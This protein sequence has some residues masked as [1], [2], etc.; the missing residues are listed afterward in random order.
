MTE[1]ELH[2]QIGDLFTKINLMKVAL[3]CCKNQYAL[4]FVERSDCLWNRWAE[5]PGQGKANVKR[6]ERID[7]GT[8]T[9]FVEVNWSARIRELEWE[10]KDEGKTAIVR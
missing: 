1:E 4:D 2:E 8:H 5:F 9:L 10:Q 6:C 3:V 7:Y